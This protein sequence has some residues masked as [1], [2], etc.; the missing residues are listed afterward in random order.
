MHFFTLN[1]NIILILLFLHNIFMFFVFAGGVLMLESQIQFSYRSMIGRRIFSLIG[2]ASSRLDD[3]TDH[4]G[5]YEVRS[6]VYAQQ[7][8]IPSVR[9]SNL[10]PPCHEPPPSP[11][12][13]R[14]RVVKP[15][16]DQ[17]WPNVY[18]AGC[19][20]CFAEQ[21]HIPLSTN[22]RYCTNVDSKPGMW[23]RQTLSGFWARCCVIDAAKFNLRS[24][25]ISKPS[26]GLDLT[27]EGIVWQG[28]FPVTHGMMDDGAE[29]WKHEA[30]ALKLNVIK[31]VLNLSN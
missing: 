16:L 27:P 9:D 29:H 8:C 3:R 24:G 14:S 26:L 4:R 23:R 31:Y 17:S 1:I 7:Q 15:L 2:P 11:I 20:L 5:P 13:H 18:D 22:T 12:R 30:L 10:R 19:F 25:L 21:I 6:T 28:S